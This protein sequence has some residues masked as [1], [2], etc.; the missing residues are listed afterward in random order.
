M[1]ATTAAV[2]PAPLRLHALGAGVHLAACDGLPAPP[3][4]GWQVFQ[5]ERPVR[6]PLARVRL[7]LG[8]GGAR[9]VVVFRPALQEVDGLAAVRIADGRGGTLAA[10]ATAPFAEAVGA[11]GSLIELTDGLE[12]AQRLRLARFVFETCAGVF[13]LCR[14]PRFLGQSRRLLRELVGQPGSLVARCAVGGGYLL[15]EG[16]VA[17][18]LGSR[19][20]AWLLTRHG[21]RRAPAPPACEPPARA[22]AGGSVIRLLLGI[23]EARGAEVLFLGEAGLA[24]RHLAPPQARLP[25]AFE[26]L[27]APDE[28]RAGARRYVLE[29]L[30]LLAAEHERAGAALRELRALVPAQ[31]ARVALG[32]GALEAGVDLVVGCATGVFASG[33]LDDREGLIEA[34]GV[35]RAGRSQTLP[36]RALEYFAHPSAAAAGHGERGFTTRRGFVLFAG[37]R[38]AGPAAAPCDIGLCLGSGQRLHLAE[39]PTRHGADAAREAVLAAVPRPWLTPELTARCLEPVVRALAPG[40][41]TIDRVLQIGPPPRSARTTVIAALGDDPD[42]IR[43]R[44]GLLAGDPATPTIDLVHVLDR[45]ERAAGARRLLEGLA[46]I[47]GIGTRLVILSGPAPG[48]AALNAAAAIAA[49]T[50]IVFLGTGVLP[51]QHGWLEQLRRRLVMQ[52]KCGIVGGRILHAD[53]S[54]SDTGAEFELVGPDRRIE[55]RPRRQGFSRDYPADRTAWRTGIVPAGAFAIRRALLETVGGLPEGYLG[56]DLALAELCLEAQARG[57]QTWTVS[58]PCL[59]DLTP[60]TASRGLDPAAELD[61]RLLEARWGDRLRATDASAT[62]TAGQHAPDALDPVALWRAA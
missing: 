5:G 10:A 15:Y 27:A 60:R 21:L 30:A 61:R 52:R 39:G 57:F 50:T 42:H 4:G 25:D 35:E 7:E 19:P 31:T 28:R 1:L 38:M 59:V 29:A 2:Q 48:A 44:Y 9:E 18:A 17:G 32:A 6:P 49:T 51:E 26:W 13:R 20:A 33:W 40:R 45:P 47:Y 41:P 34:I 56:L 54:V 22:A 62:T 46:A 14:D 53:D 24:C 3:R 16:P 36:L 58:T 43:C 37:E 55:V 8:S 11:G 12:P 23:D